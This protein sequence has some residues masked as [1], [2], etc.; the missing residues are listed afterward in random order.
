MA[1]F[2]IL[3]AQAGHFIELA[4]S[5]FVLIIIC[6]IVQYFFVTDK[7]SFLS[8]PWVKIF[9]FMCKN[10]VESIRDFFLSVSVPYSSFPIY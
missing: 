6:L 1:I 3:F 7:K 5:F 10:K 9:S 2:S 8:E 4:D